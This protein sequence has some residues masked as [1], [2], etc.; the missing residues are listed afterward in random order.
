MQGTNTRYE[1]IEKYLTI[2][3]L[4]GMNTQCKNTVWSDLALCTYDNRL[5]LGS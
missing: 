4:P 1:D 2:E 5:K 3:T